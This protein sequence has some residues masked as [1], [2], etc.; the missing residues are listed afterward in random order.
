MRDREGGVLCVMVVVVIDREEEYMRG[1]RCGGE[2]GREE[3]HR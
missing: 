3:D 1:L 2:T